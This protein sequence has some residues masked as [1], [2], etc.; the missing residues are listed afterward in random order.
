MPP[1]RLFQAK[2]ALLLQ[3]PRLDK[4]LSRQTLLEFSGA[5]AAC[6]EWAAQ[7][8]ALQVFVVRA[9]N[10]TAMLATLWV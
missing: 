1:A 2:W 10:P 6:A 4:R 7:A 3:P 5:W 8:P 9:Q